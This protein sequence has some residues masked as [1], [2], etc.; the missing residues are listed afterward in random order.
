M[1]RLNARQLRSLNGVILALYD[2]G[3]EPD[4]L[5]S[6]MNLFDVLVPHSSIS[7]DEVFFRSNRVEHRSGRRL[8]SIPDVEQKVALFCGENPLIAR[9][10]AGHFEPAQRLSNFTSFR[11]FKQTAFYQEVARFLPG[12]RDQ[13]AVAI[14]LPESRL[15]F[16]L[17]RDRT[18]ADEELLMLEL[19]HPHL[20]R[21][22]HRCT[23]YLALVDPLTIC[24]R[25][26]LHW[27]AEGKR[28]SEIGT[29]LGMSV[30]TVEQHVGSCL[31]KLGVETRAAATAE[32]WR[33]RRR[34]G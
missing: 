29:I 15:G 24:E 2:E 3:S 5:E 11:E 14:R 28:D 13:A 7:I 8:E 34:S 12:W 23:Q 25:K 33:A 19:L 31:R 1:T 9:A 20:E 16:A 32:V 27:V 10:R 17:N 18:Y 6:I 4:R 22:L 30:R 26:V 21:V